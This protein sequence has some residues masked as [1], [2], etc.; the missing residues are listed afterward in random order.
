MIPGHSYRMA[1]E[2]LAVITVWMYVVVVVLAP[3][4]QVYI[5]GSIVIAQW[6]IAMGLWIERRLF[7]HTFLGKLPTRRRFAY[8]S[9]LLVGVA[10]VGI[11]FLGLHLMFAD[12]LE[13][14]ERINAY[15][16][17]GSCYLRVG[18]K[19]AS[20]VDLR[21]CSNSHLLRSSAFF[22]A[23]LFV[24]TILGWYGWKL[25]TERSVGSGKVAT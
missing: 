14:G 19:T 17:D 12:V 22:G 16:A 6:L 25:E 3:D 15:L 13:P 23:A 4:T 9:C 10:G 7:H 24:S 1:A 5:L 21:I 20:Q 18:K 2:F 11:G 8:F